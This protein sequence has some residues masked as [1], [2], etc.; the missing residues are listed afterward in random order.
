[1]I[2]LFC[3]AIIVTERDDLQVRTYCCSHCTCMS[4]IYVVV[5]TDPVLAPYI[6]E[7]HVVKLVVRPV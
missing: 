4:Q 7:H 1:M 6:A 2:V 5:L 3:M